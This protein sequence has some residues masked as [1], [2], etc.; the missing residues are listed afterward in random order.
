MMGRGRASCSSPGASGGTTLRGAAVG[1][2]LGA[3][4]LG[5]SGRGASLLEEGAGAGGECVCRG[6]RPFFFRS[7]LALGGRA[8]PLSSSVGEGSLQVLPGPCAPHEPP[9]HGEVSGQRSGSP[10]RAVLGV[11]GTCQDSWPEPTMISTIRKRDL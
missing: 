3:V 6:L 7:P 1:L 8:L 11:I 5:G 9:Q 4:W 10:T 2:S